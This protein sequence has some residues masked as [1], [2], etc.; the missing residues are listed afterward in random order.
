MIGLR[1]RLRSERGATAVLVGIVVPLLL[2]MVGLGSEVMVLSAA[3]RELQRTADQ[4]ALAAAAQRPVVD[5]G[6]IGGFP[7]LAGLLAGLLHPGAPS[8]ADIACP[9][10]EH[11]AERSQVLGAFAAQLPT[12]DNGLV[13]VTPE[14]DASDV[15]NEAE[16]L[17]GDLTGIAVTP[18]L[19]ALLAAVGLP[20]DVEGL[21]PAV[22]TPRVRVS[23]TGDV[24]TAFRQLIA[25]DG[26]PSTLTREAVARRR[27]KNVLLLPTV[28][29][30]GLPS[31]LPLTDAVVN[32]LR[33][34]LGGTELAHLLDSLGLL[35]IQPLIDLLDPLGLLGLGLDDVIAALGVDAVLDTVDPS[36]ELPLDEALTAAGAD[37]E[38]DLNQ[39]LDVAVD[40]TVALLE[41]ARDLAAA[42]PLPGAD[43]LA[44]LI[45]VLLTD[46]SDL[47]DPGSAAPTLLEVVE[48]AANADEDV[49]VVLVGATHVPLLDLFAVPGRA[50][51]DAIAAQTGGGGVDVPTLLADT[52]TVARSVAAAQ[53]AFRASL[54]Q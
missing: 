39:P 46:L 27:F 10:A 20:V 17:L 33:D 37:C 18:T 22:A 44:G 41:D 12:C 26:A 36:D 5:T 3:D 11:N 9:T 1:A 45:D 28:P 30:C 50:L 32:L 29:L 47:L 48:A 35:D 14:S 49:L 53:G 4:A 52:G 42:L 21:I 24:T 7:L 31:S 38:V 40:A 34:T 23:V 54:V 25:D 8:A 2:A 13:T 19:E 51:Q 43:H 15:L 6:A 16:G